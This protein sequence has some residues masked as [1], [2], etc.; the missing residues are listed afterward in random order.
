MKIDFTINGFSDALILPDDHE[1]TDDEIADM[2][3]A[4]YDKWYAIVTAPSE[5]E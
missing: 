4:R 2:K 3:Q 5:E 1:F